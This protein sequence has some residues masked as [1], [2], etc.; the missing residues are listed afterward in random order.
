MNITEE[1]KH[2][3]GSI[4]Q[5]SKDLKTDACCTTDAMPSH[6]KA[7]LQHIHPEVQSRYYGCGLVI[8]EALEGCHILDLGCGSGRDVFL[9]S[10]MV[11]EQGSVTGVDMTEAQLEIAIRHQDYHRERLGYSRPNTD[12]VEGQ[13][14]HLLDLD[15]PR[16]S[17]DIVIS[18]CVLNLVPDKSAVLEQVFE[19]LKPG[20]EFYF[21]DVYADRR[22]AD[23]LR[24]DPV[25][26]GECLGGALYWNDFL[27]LAKAA[28]FADP[29][30]VSDRPLSI[31]DPQ[32]QEKLGNTKFYSATYRL[33]KIQGLESSCEDYGQA[34]R[35]KGSISHHEQQFLLDKHHIIETGRI[36]PVCGNT[37]RMLKETRFA[38]HFD[39][40][41]D[42]GTHFGIFQGCGTGLPFDDAVPH[43][44]SG[45]CC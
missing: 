12:F 26:Y 40:F 30:L 7:L 34:V 31:D 17:F 35:Y 41:G 20:G 33:I 42:A 36:F 25:L 44:E 45:G 13:L 27:R 15:L 21:S 6:L 22:V 9:L 18:N 10:A 2:Y 38:P 24:S 39:F 3:Y 16:G 32:Q 19:L 29:R 4:L 37:Y 8:P 43:P 5:G 1:V 23:D 28:G 11:G 14:E